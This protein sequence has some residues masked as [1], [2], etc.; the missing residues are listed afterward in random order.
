MTSVFGKPG[1]RP[2]T[3]LRASAR[4]QGAPPM[5]G[6]NY[7]GADY[8]E[9]RLPEPPQELTPLAKE[10]ANV[11][12]QVLRGLQNLPP[13]N[14]NT[15][16]WTDPETVKVWVDSDF[17]LVRLTE[18]VV[19][20]HDRCVDVTLSPYHSSE[21]PV[22]QLEFR[23]GKSR[24]H[25]DD[26]RVPYLFDHVSEIREGIGIEVLLDSDLRARTPQPDEE[27]P[28]LECRSTP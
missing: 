11:L 14:W 12:G 21:G 17:D 15:A 5:Q 16:K 26:H 3:A 25:S 7:F 1:P 27:G 22:L 10:V 13:V 18:L 24:A 6:A 9:V 19:L 28:D 20:A 2:M 23:L 4:I 8:L